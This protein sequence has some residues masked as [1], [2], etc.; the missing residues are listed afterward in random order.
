ML[1]SK[2]RLKSRVAALMVFCL[3]G[4]PVAPLMQAQAPGAKPAAA[5]AAAA[6]TPP[7]G[8]WPR[9]Y[10]TASK[11][12]LV[13]YQPQLVSW[14]DQKHA[15]MYAALSYLPA[16]REAAGARHHQGG[17][18][19][20]RGRRRAARELLGLQD[21][22]VQLPHD[23]ARSAQDRRR[24]DRRVAARR[25]AR[26]SR[27]T[28][29]SPTW[30]RAW[31]SRRTSRASRPI[32]R[33]SSSARRPPCSSTSTASRSGRPSR[34][35]TSSRRSTPTGISSS[36]RPTK[37]YYLRHDRIWLKATDVKGP[38]SPAGT[39]PESFKKLP[40]DENWKDVKASLPGQKV[41]GSQAPKVFVSYEPAEMILL[42]GEPSYLT[43]QGAKQLLWVNNT[44]SDVFR[45]GRT[46]PVYFLVSGRWFSAPDFTGPWTF[47]TPSLP[48]DFKEIPLEH[49]RSRVLASVPG[50][51]Q[52]TEAVL[53]AQIPQTARVSKKGVQAPGS[54]VSGRSARVPADR[55]DDRAARGQHGQGHPEG[56]RPLL[57]VLPGRL[58]HVDDGHGPVAGHRRGAEGRSTRSRSAR[59]RTTSPT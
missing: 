47:A 53:L 32:R 35:T 3:I 40:D 7:D 39:L 34:R 22:R 44:D 36:T 46:G 41:S 16:A 30:T 23:P 1:T 37:T 9:S 2:V 38:W 4:S 20:Q 21:R 15:V 25:R 29:S 18:Q 24:G 28:V 51:Q 6:A 55:E 54:R 57:H 5:P 31:W 52:A 33:R 12:A 58:V 27:S 19:H 42:R 10:T 49:E 8:G 43:V 14:T 56:R 13:M 50:T 45:M 17:S 48:A 26:A 11:A 59:P